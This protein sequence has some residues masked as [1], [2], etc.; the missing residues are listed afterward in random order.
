MAP[1]KGSLLRRWRKVVVG[2]RSYRQGPTRVGS[3]SMLVDAHLDGVQLVPPALVGA[4]RAALKAQGLDPEAI[5]L[6]GELNPVGLLSSAF[7]T[8]EIRTRLT[9]PIAL[10]LRGPP[11]PAIRRTLEQIQPAIVLRGR[12]GRYEIAPLGVPAGPVDLSASG[13]KLGIGVGA[14]LLGLLLI[15]AAAFGR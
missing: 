13:T 6:N 8:V 1:V 3:R 11:D 2:W 5:A 10:N 7:D 12:A 4:A 14:G 9:P 15:G